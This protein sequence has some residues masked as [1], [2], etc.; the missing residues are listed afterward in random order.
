MCGMNNCISRTERAVERS[1]TREPSAV[2]AIQPVSSSGTAQQGDQSP[3]HSL[4]QDQA[5]AEESIATSAEYA[6]VHARIADIVG[7][8]RSLGRAATVDGAADEIQTM[9]PTPQ[10]LVTL[11]DRKRAV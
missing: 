3:R 2:S 1:A 4:A 8:L 9:L 7:D 10:V 11:P 5:G 6:K